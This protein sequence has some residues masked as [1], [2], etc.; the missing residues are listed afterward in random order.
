MYSRFKPCLKTKKQAYCACSFYMRVNNKD[1]E[2]V[3][4]D[5]CYSDNVDV[6]IYEPRHFKNASALIT[7]DVDCSTVLTDESASES[8]WAKVP[9]N[10]RYFQ[11]A[12]LKSPCK[13]YLVKK[14]TRKIYFLF[15]ID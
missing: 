9:V 8:E 5:F 2:F 4:I 12:Q 6:P 3:F 10:F 14:K 1:P 11:C 15:K 13:Q 7:S